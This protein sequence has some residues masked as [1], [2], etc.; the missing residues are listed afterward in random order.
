M[1]G[2]YWKASLGK[3]DDSNAVEL[4]QGFLT[5]ILKLAE[6]PEQTLKYALLLTR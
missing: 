6:R 4:G 2:S 1:Q 3:L 5:G